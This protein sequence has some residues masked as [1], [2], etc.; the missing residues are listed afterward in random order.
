MKTKNLFFRQSDSVTSNMQLLSNTELQGKMPPQ[1]IELEQSILGAL[2]LEKD[3]L[4]EVIDILKPTSFYE[5]THQEI[6][7]AILQLFN[8]SAPIDL[9]TVV[10]Q[11][12]KNGKL[13]LVGGSYY[14]ASLTARVI[15]AANI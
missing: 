9:R 1:A 13:E 3:A 10:N 5:E 8:A 4:T 7:T 14:L 15:S 2:M 6:Y 11:L 12:R